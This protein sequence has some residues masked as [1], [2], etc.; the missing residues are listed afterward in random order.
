M[1]RQKE[2][3]PWQLSISPIVR[4]GSSGRA[5]TAFALGCAR[6]V[7]ARFSSAGGKKGASALRFDHSFP[8]CCR[9]RR[10]E[11]FERLRRGKR[12]AGRFCRIVFLPNGLAYGRL[13]IAVSRKRGRAVQR[14]RFRRIVREV[15]RQHR[16]RHAPVDVLVI[17]TSTLDARQRGLAEEL[18]RLFD[19]AL[20]QLELQR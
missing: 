1:Q 11:D 6:K 5:S 8:R 10:A 3:E 14:N 18:G 19:A 15:F 12:L 17:A 13:G 2:T 7:D 4:A 20:Q 9:L 16:I